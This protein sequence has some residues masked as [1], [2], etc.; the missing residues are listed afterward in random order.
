MDSIIDTAVLE[1]IVAEFANPPTPDA[2][3]SET[4]LAAT[5]EQLQ[6]SVATGEMLAAQLREERE[7]T[8]LLNHELSDAIERW[9]AALCAGGITTAYQVR[10]RAE[11]EIARVAAKAREIRARHRGGPMLAL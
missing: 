8:S 9:Q 3:D 11:E 10:Q 4:L 7:I 6:R 1:R 2:P 5:T